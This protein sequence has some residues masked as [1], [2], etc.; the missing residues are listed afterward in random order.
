MKHCSFLYKKQNE[1]INYAEMTERLCVQFQ[2]I[3][4]K[5]N[6]VLSFYLENKQLLTLLEN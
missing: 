1:V 4:S 5:G 3:S 6:A 2:E